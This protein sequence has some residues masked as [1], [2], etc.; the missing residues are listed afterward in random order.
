MK[1]E[2]CKLYSGVFWIFPSNSIKIDRYNSELYTVSK[3]VH[4]W[5]T[6]YSMWHT[7]VLV[8]DI[9]LVKLVLHQLWQATIDLHCFGNKTI[10]RIMGDTMI[11]EFRNFL[12]VF[13]QYR[14]LTHRR[15]DIIADESLWTRDSL[16]ATCVTNGKIYLS[17]V[18]N[19]Q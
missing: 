4:F 5:E 15:T 13:I 3:L 10:S 11:K 1:T 18:I 19:R 9:K 16:T 7:I 6:V 12:A 2:T 17:P 14:S 8:N